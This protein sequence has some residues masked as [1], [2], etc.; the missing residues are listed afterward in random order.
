MIALAAAEAETLDINTKPLPSYLALLTPLYREKARQHL[1][2]VRELAMALE[3]HLSSPLNATA[4]LILSDALAQA[5]T[6]YRAAL[7]SFAHAASSEGA[8]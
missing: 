4:T 8:A 3:G 2:E 7:T 1:G 6:N 5:H